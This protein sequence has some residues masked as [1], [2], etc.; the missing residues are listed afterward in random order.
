LKLQKEKVRGLMK[1]YA[2]DNYHELARMLGLDAAHV[3]RTL[4][5]PGAGAGPKFLGAL[6]TFCK[7][8][9]LNFQEYIF[10]DNLLIT[11]NDKT[12]HY[13]KPQAV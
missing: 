12:E 6:F 10:L 13:E 11:C 9:K 1:D 2:K 8:R 4:N 5:N 3:Y 7:E